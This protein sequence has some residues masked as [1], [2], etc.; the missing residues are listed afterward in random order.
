MGNWPTNPDSYYNFDPG[1]FATDEDE[2]ELEICSGCNYSNCQC[3]AAS[4]YYR[5]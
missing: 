3:D 2:E 4:D 1:F 5:D